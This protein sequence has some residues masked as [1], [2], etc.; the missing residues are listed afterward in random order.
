MYICVY[1]GQVY[2]YMCV[3]LGARCIH[4]YCSFCV[5]LSRASHAGEYPSPRLQSLLYGGAENSWGVGGGGAC[6]GDPSELPLPEEEGSQV[7]WSPLSV[8]G[9]SLA[10]FPPMFHP[11]KERL[12]PSSLWV[13]GPLGRETEDSDGRCF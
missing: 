3:Y 9:L 12:S 2:V 11:Q 5:P 13:R 7:S 10:K 6:H 1:L 8:I 4:T